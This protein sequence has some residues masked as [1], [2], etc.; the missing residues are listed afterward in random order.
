MPSNRP[1]LEQVTKQIAAV[2]L[3]VLLVLLIYRRDWYG[4]FIL[5]VSFA[6]GYFAA[7]FL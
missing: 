2:A 4:A 5:A 7:R 6:G 3:V 1:T